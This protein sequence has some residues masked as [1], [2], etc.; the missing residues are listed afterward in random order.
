VFVGIGLYPV[1]ASI[2]LPIEFKSV[3]ANTG[4]FLANTISTIMNIATAVRTKHTVFA[5]GSISAIL[6]SYGSIIINDYL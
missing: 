5:I 3:W 1:T 4:L 2:T 6:S